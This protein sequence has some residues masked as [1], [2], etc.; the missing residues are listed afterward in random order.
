MNGNN[1]FTFANIVLMFPFISLSTGRRVWR[2]QVLTLK[3]TDNGHLS[4]WESPLGSWKKRF[5]WTVVES[6]KIRTYVIHHECTLRNA[7]GMAFAW[8]RR[9]N[10]FINQCLFASIFG[11]EIWGIIFFF[12]FFS[13]IC[14]IY[15]FRIVLSNECGQ[16]SY[17]E[18]I[19]TLGLT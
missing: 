10:Y 2:C 18:N 6:T 12:F 11:R 9:S 14:K 13:K 4:R 8:F 1:I 17:C 19:C 5:Y 7:A 16:N 3:Y 15:I